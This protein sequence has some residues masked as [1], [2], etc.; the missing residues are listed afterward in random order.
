[1]AGGTADTEGVLGGGAEAGPGG[2]EVS[3][4]EAT[5]RAME[6]LD[7]RL[8]ER[9][10]LDRTRFDERLLQRESAALATLEF[11]LSM[12]TVA[13]LKAQLRARGL[14]LKGLKADLVRRL[15][16]DQAREGG[17]RPLGTEVPGARSNEDLE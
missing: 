1:M 7:V 9:E 17:G 13:Q 16:R 11:E 4:L 12:L 15:A 10:R 14:K 3:T 6:S 5:T 8:H 2:G